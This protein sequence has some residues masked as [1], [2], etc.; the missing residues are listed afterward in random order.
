[1]T[2]DVHE[3]EFKLTA[4][5]AKVEP[6]NLRAG[7]TVALPPPQWAACSIGTCAFANRGFIRGIGGNESAFAVTPNK[8]TPTLQVK[9]PGIGLVEIQRAAPPTAR[10]RTMSAGSLFNGRPRGGAPAI[11]LPATLA[12]AA[13]ILS[14]EKEPGAN[15]VLSLP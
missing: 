1:M 15:A 6:R 7:G 8:P 5:Y 4:T 10:G 12:L 2:F 9:N 14:P 3:V 11:V 13:P